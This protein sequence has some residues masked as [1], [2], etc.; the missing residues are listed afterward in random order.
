M[1]P[2]LF[3]SLSSFGSPPNYWCEKPWR[4]NHLRKCLQAVALRTF[5]IGSFLPVPSTFLKPNISFPL[6][7]LMEDW[8]ACIVCAPFNIAFSQCRFM[9]SAVWA[10]SYSIYAFPSVVFWGQTWYISVPSVAPICTALQTSLFICR[11]ASAII[12]GTEV[13]ENVAIYVT[14]GSVLLSCSSRVLRC[15]HLAA[16]VVLSA[17]LP[18]APIP[19]STP[20]ALFANS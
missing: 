6:D 17:T 16:A 20:V 10:T 4:Q 3:T 9:C 2:S 12:F 11:S 19:L 7:C 14:G 13:T 1:V 5:L 18:P 8:A 15:F